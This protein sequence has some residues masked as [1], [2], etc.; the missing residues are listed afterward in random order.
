VTRY[1]GFTLWELLCVLTIAGVSL[2]WGA[3]ALRGLLSDARR[4]SE[5]NAFVAAVQLARS[6]SAKRARSVVLCKTEDWL[7][8]GGSE[9]R[10]DAGWMVFVNEDGT[11]PPHRAPGEPL[12]LARRPRTGA[13]ATANRHL[14]EFR[15]FGLRSTNG[16][17]TFCDWRGAAAARAVIVSYTGRPRV[18]ADAPDGAP[19][20]C[21]AA[22]T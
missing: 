12:L 17:V 9:M 4:T 3:P 1:V 10:F 21:E 7:R 13:S 15:P 5:V 14:F 11:R 2:A 8:C 20:S 22:G 18:S 16:T 6:E 19:L